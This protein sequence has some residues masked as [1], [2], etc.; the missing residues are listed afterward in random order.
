MMSECDETANRPHGDTWAFNRAVVIGWCAWLLGSWTINMDVQAPIPAARWMIYSGLIGMTMAWPMWRLS[1]AIVAPTA[2]TQAYGVFVDWLNLNLVFQAVLWPLSLTTRWSEPQTL[3]LA[4]ALGAWSLL[5]AAIV[6]WGTHVPLHTGKRRA[7]AMILCLA[8]P[9][10][11]PAVLGVMNL[12]ASQP[13]AV[14]WPMHLSPIQTLWGL[15]VQ[16]AYWP[17]HP[18]V[19]PIWVALGLAVLVWAWVIAASRTTTVLDPR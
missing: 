13:S 17:Q 9:L 12:E 7:V 11:E 18:F 6:A 14:T 16:P 1:I 19:T 5:A 15:T 8:V 3:W 10:G 4:A 2:P